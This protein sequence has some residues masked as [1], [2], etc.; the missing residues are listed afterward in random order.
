[1]PASD[2]TFPTRSYLDRIGLRAA[3]IAPGLDPDR[4]RATVCAVARAQHAA[5]PFENLDIHRGDCVR[6]DPARL[7]TRLID[8]RRGGICYQ[9]NGLLALALTA[10]GVPVTLWGARVDSGAGPGPADGH[11]AVI[12][13][14]APG[15]RL[16]VDVGFG[17]ER[18]VRPIDPD[19]PASLT[20]RLDDARYVLD[21]VDRELAEFADMARWHSSSPQSRFTGS[22]LCTLPAGDGG[23]RTLTGRI[24]QPGG[25]IDYR[26]I[27]TTAAG[28]RS[29]RP[30]TIDEAA[31]VLAEHFGMPAAAVPAVSVVVDHSNRH[32]VGNGRPR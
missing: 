27:A 23:R 22:V 21:P 7:I 3:V 17:G 28:D 9:L 2:V 18:V 16:L 32:G 4:R 6:V 5:V 13:E 20:V 31:A 14:P 11:L 15:Q 10:L 12:A 1:M 8:D 29:A 30:V 19:D 26:V 24:A 25:R